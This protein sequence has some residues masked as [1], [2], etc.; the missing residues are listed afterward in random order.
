MQYSANPRF[1]IKCDGRELDEI[2]RIA[3]TGIMVESRL[4]LPSA[5]AITLIDRKLSFIEK[6]RGLLREGVELEIALGYGQQHIKLIEGEISAVSVEMS[7]KGVFTY[8]AGFD[9]LHCLTRGTTYYRYG[10]GA[11]NA[12]ED[13][14]IA[15]TLIHEAGLDPVVDE[16]HKRNTP[17]TQ[18][19]RSDLDF[20]TMLAKLNGFYLYAED[21]TVY[22]TADPPDRG[23]MKLE[24]GKGLHRFSASLSLNSLV[25]TLVTRGRDV[26]LGENFEEKLEHPA[27]D[28]LL[29]SDVGRDLLGRDQNQKSTLYLYDALVTSAQDA[30]AFLGSVMRERQTIVVAEGSCT[31]DPRLVAG[32]DLEIAGAERFDGIYLVTRAVHRYNESGY[33][34]E[35]EAKKTP[36]LYKFEQEP[37]VS[38]QGAGVRDLG[39]GISQQG[40]G[41]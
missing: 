5:F 39:A 37:R 25:T 15:W 18:N 1:T 36:G 28:L 26:S 13:S 19:N 24:W 14:L 3:V 16:T 23:Y 31:G 35:F 17:R 6:N 29:I 10:D 40:P 27:D 12:H 20:L 33:T 22:F 2:E 34:T 7:P 32:V 38:E 9:Y 30:K 21:K 8:V 11:D 4:D 41:L